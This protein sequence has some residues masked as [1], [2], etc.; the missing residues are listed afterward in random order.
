MRLGPPNSPR[1]SRH[2]WLLH[3][4]VVGSDVLLRCISWLQRSNHKCY[5][6]RLSIPAAACNH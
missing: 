1:L 4:R 3:H 6:I 2:Q 5:R